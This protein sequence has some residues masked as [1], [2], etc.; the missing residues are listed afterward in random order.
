M[1]KRQPS[2]YGFHGIY[3]ANPTPCMQDCYTALMLAAE[4]RAFH[5]VEKLLEL[6]AKVDEVEDKVNFIFARTHRRKCACTVPTAIYM[7]QFHQFALALWLALVCVQEHQTVLMSAAQSRAFD[8]L[9]KLIAHGANVNGTNTVRFSKQNPKT[10][11]SFLRVTHLN[12]NSRV[13]RMGY[14]FRCFR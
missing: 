8:M 13:V 10:D 12:L 2:S 3:H 5:T 6:K 4:S 14:A 7:P 11:S 9:A 1:P